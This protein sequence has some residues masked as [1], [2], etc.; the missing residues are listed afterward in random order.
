MEHE[1]EGQAFA[2]TQ[3]AEIPGGHLYRVIHLDYRGELFG[4]GGLTFV[5]TQPAGEDDT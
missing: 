4:V 5:P 2:M 3:R 1:H